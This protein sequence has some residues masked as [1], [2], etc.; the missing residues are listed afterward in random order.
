MKN[1]LEQLKAKGVAV[2]EITFDGYADSGS[3]E[4]VYCCDKDNQEVQV[5]ELRQALEQLGYAVL[6]YHDI[7]FD[8]EGCFGSITL[9]VESGKVEIEVNT[10]YTAYDTESHQASVD[11]YL[12]KGEKEEAR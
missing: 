2:V 10:R 12:N 3:I 8:D 5:G 11:R 4:E 1:L 7:G 6:D 9:E